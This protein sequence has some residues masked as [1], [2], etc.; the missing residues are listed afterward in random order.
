M[1]GDKIVR[2]AVGLLVGV[3]LARY[4]GPRLFGEFSY[5]I[6]FVMI[7]SP[8]AMLSLDVI[9][10]RRLVKDPSARNE[11]LGTS[12]VLM[13]IG[14]SIALA[15]AIAAILLLR[16]EDRLVQWL[17]GILTA[18]SIVQAFIAIEFWFESQVQ[19]KFTVYA[20]TSAFLLLSFAKIGLILAGAPL[21]AFAWAG[22]A[23][24]V[25]GSIGL[26]LVYRRRGYSIRAWRFSRS[27]ARSLLA[28]SWPL[29]VSVFLTMV[30]MRIDQIMIGSMIGSR[31]LGNYSVAVQVSEVWYFVPMV[32]CSS[33]FP[34]VIE[35]EAFS[36]ELFYDRM[37]R[38]YNLM[39]FLTYAAAVPVALFSDEIIRLL[40]SA[41]YADA[42]PL[43][44]ILIWTGVFISFGAA[45]NLLIVAKNWTRVNMVSIA[46]G[47]AMNILLNTLLIPKHGAMG[48]VVAT[49]ISYWCASHGTFFLFKSLRKSGLMMLKAMFYPK[50]W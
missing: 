49:F 37:Q 7:V 15:L 20:R 6:A 17:V 13:V 26:I 21:V 31:E 3:L 43:L 50:F 4:L 27:M 11:V 41:D 39:A 40:F 42:A 1:M 48:A 2:K 34:A 44:A 9:S 28:D 10:I 33:V 25:A 8:V 12:F 47:C 36:E 46:L 14:G 35:A 29:I 23:E 19:W 32:L 22:F 30:Y 16:P 24:T 45:R 5:S 38:L 18:A